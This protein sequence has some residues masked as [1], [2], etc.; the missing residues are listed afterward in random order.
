MYRLIRRRFVPNF[1]PGEK[2]R[3]SD[4]VI[5]SA[6]SITANIA[7][8]YGRFHYLDEAKFLSN[9]R[10]SLTETLDHLITA[11][12]DGYITDSEL[13]EA[14]LQIDETLRLLN[15]YRAYILRRAKED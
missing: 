9:S 11:N 12:D 13:N 10:G 14:R 7:E 5:R 3:L 6:R 2:F 8:G 15:G 4:Q 1:P